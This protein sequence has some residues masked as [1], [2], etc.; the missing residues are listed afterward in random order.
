M[1]DLPYFADEAFLHRL[2]VCKLCATAD[3]SPLILYIFQTLFEQA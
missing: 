3:V 1:Q 2:F